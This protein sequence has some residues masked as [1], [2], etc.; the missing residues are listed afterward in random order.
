MACP[1]GDAALGRRIGAACALLILQVAAAATP[2]SADRRVNDVM[3]RPVQTP[4]DIDIHGNCTQLNI[5]EHC[6][7]TL[8]KPARDV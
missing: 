7:T 8:K 4:R 6:A 2:A 1:T 5:S 3:S